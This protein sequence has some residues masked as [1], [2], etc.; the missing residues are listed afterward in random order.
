MEASP[1]VPV[2]PSNATA[3]PN[4]CERVSEEEPSHSTVWPSESSPTTAVG[5]VE[6]SWYC[7]L[8]QGEMLLLGLEMVDKAVPSVLK[9]FMPSTR[10]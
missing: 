10:W 6:R 8:A 4:P 7:T 5:G 3:L 2:H 1:D 9:T